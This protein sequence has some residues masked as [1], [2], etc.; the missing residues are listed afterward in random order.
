VNVPENGA[1]QMVANPGWGPKEKATNGNRD[2][3]DWMGWNA[4]GDDREQIGWCEIDLGA[5]VWIDTIRIWHYYGD[6]RTYHDVKLAV[7]KTGKFAGEEVVIF[8]GEEETPG[9]AKSWIADVADDD[10][11][12]FDDF[13]GGEYVETAGGRLDH[14]PPVE[15]R[16]IR[17]WSSGNTSNPAVHWVE[18]EA[19][20]FLGALSVD[21]KGKLAILWGSVKST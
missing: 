19:Y 5:V 17:D 14:F 15:A 20:S 10:N 13:D 1:D 8:D 9:R 4:E 21:G 3:A 6:G 7:S 12:N 16:Y 2:T 11:A 18:I